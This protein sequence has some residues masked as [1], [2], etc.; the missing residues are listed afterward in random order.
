MTFL[1]HPGMSACQALLVLV[2]LLIVGWSIRDN[3]DKKTTH[4]GG[5]RRFFFKALG[6]ERDII[7]KSTGHGN[8][9]ATAVFR[10]VP[11][12]QDIW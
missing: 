10:M 6:D 1:P 4:S 9:R 3:E 2:L 5:V 11:P 7:L 8:I 12:R